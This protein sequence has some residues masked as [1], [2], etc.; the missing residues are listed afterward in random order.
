MDF[1]YIQILMEIQKSKLDGNPFDG[2]PRNPLVNPYLEV[3]PIFRQE[4]IHKELSWI[5]WLM[6]FRTTVFF[7]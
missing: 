7:F 5:P 1:V 2:N 6:L 3:Y 4:I